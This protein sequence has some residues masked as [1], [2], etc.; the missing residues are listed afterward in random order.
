MLKY[1]LRKLL[2]LIP[3][4]LAISLIL[5][6]AL[7]CLPGDPLTRAIPY[8]KYKEMPETMRVQLREDLGLNDP[9][10]V[11]YIRWLGDILQGDLGYS[12]STGD[13]IGK[14]VAGRLPY[15]I[16]LSTSAVVMATII[17]ILLGFFA[18]IRKNSMI[19]YT[20]TT[21]SVLGQSV[22][23]FFFGVLFLILFAI[24]WKA[25][26]VG[27]RMSAGDGSLGD[28]ISHMI[29]P[30]MTMAVGLLGAMTRSTRG[31]MVDVMNK[32]YVKTARSKGLSESV[33][34]VK[35]V[36]RNALIPVLTMV[37]MRLPMLFGG[38]VVA[39][40]VF[41]YPGMGK[42]ALD[43]MNAGDIPVVM[44]GTMV[45]AVVTLTASALVDVVTALVDPRVR[46]E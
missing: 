2:A 14:M 25:L 23:D 37:T 10:P 13:S 4:L 29:L 34:N 22:P 8:D 24:T 16:A 18:A 46:L 31:C 6:I 11:R 44:I 20:A 21:V 28:L 19:D 38:S 42:M 26:P 12:T 33:I 36:F 5:F 15:T 9:A 39:E 3:K 35:H 30:S 17:G 7:E 32:D 43:A 40:Q 1:I 41:N 27:G 45:I